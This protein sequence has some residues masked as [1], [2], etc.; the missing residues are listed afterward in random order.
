MKK[1]TI[2]AFE[3]YPETIDD[4]GL[5]KIT[6]DLV[7][8]HGF[9]FVVYWPNRSVCEIVEV[10]TGLFAIKIGKSRGNSPRIDAIRKLKNISPEYMQ[11][12]IDRFVA[13]LRKLKRANPSVNN[14]PTYPIN[15]RR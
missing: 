9:Q 12:C 8:I 13:H 14:M 5:K 4:F 1:V 6:G 3:W 15:P 10:S 11:E 7:E 2:K